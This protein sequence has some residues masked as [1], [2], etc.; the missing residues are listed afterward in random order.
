MICWCFLFPSCFIFLFLWSSH[1]EDRGRLQVCQEEI[2]G[3]IFSLPDA[4][5]P[6]PIETWLKEF[7]DFYT[8]ASIWSRFGENKGDDGGMR[9]LCKTPRHL[10]GAWQWFQGDILKHLLVMESQR[11]PSNNRAHMDEEL[12]HTRHDRTSSAKYN[13]QSFFLS[14]PES[15]YLF[16]LQQSWTFLLQ[17]TWLLF[18]CQCGG[19]ASYRTMCENLVMD[20]MS[21]MWF[22][23]RASD[24]V[25]FLPT[26]VPKRLLW[27]PPSSP[28]PTAAVLSHL[29]EPLIRRLMVIFLLLP[30]SYLKMMMQKCLFT[31]DL[32]PP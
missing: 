27:R 13:T 23:Q 3:L 9:P 29:I 22:I 26:I 19:V 7:I 12:I 10:E 20:Q 18:S 15:V 25:I 17:T 8:Q 32:L 4:E 2:T 14:A 28:V 5:G 24:H 31:A 16:Q 6:D 1:G 21:Q 30:S 11:C